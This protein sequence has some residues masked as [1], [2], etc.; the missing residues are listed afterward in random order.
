MKTKNKTSLTLLIVVVIIGGIYFINDRYL[1]QKKEAVFCPT[2][3]DFNKCYVYRCNTGYIYNN[4]KKLAPGNNP[5]D[6]SDGS[7]IEEVR[8]E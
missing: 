3:G 5:L 2:T 1:K 4:I 7:K 6:C 8:E